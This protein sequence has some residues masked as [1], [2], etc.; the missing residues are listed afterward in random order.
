[1]EVHSDKRRRTIVI[2]DK[3]S[4]EETEEALV[5]IKSVL[6]H[7]KNIGNNIKEFE[8][9]WDNLNS[10]DALFL[11]LQGRRQ[12][13]KKNL[14]LLTKPSKGDVYKKQWDSI[15]NIMNKDIS[16][17]YDDY[18]LNTDTKFYVYAHCD[19]SKQIDINSKSAF[20]T[21][22]ASLGMKYLPFYIGKGTGDRVQKGDRNRNYSK[23]SSKK[24]TEVD[25]LVLKDKLTESEA[26]QLESKLIDIFGLAIHGGLLVNIDEGL[27]RDIRRFQYSKELSE[28]RRIEEVL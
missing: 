16:S 21:F 15:Q 12:Q 19:S 23:I 1:M 4:V 3:L 20:H 13:L 2:L 8:V 6:R 7:L 22:A 9:D 27:N 17:L 25:K 26:F 14:G 10:I 28:L 24:Y 5:H 11:K 18:T